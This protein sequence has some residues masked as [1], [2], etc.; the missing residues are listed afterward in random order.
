MFKLFK[1]LYFKPSVNEYQHHVF[2]SIATNEVAIN[3]HFDWK[4]DWYY[5]QND[6]LFCNGYEFAVLRNTSFSMTIYPFST[7]SDYYDEK[8][9]SFDWFLAN[10]SDTQNCCVLIHLRF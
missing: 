10:L 9:K 4:H 2:T 6:Y 5:V 3:I 1:M 7:A 8:Y